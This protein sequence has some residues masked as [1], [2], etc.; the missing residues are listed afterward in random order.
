ML[1]SFSIKMYGIKKTDKKYIL[2]G[3]AFLFLALSFI[4]RFIVHGMVYTS[5]NGYDVSLITAL[6]TNPHVYSGVIFW[7]LLLF[8]VFRLLGIVLLFFFFEKNSNLKTLILLLFFGGVV[9]FLS[10]YAY[11][12]FHFTSLILFILIAS[13]LFKTY[14]S[15][16]LQLTKLFFWSFMLLGLCQSLFMF[17]AVDNLFF[18]LGEFIQLCAYALLAFALYRVSYIA[19]KRPT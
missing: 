16:K 3:S 15:K 8:R 10:S 11:F 9:G 7:T 4:L 5:G 18:V 1:L 14:M 19:K 13:S 6:H 17:I 2:L 12:M